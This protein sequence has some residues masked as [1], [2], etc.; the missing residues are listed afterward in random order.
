M[1]KILKTKKLLPLLLSGILFLVGCGKT[2]NEL[3]L[4]TA[5][6]QIEINVNEQDRL[7]KY[8]SPYTIC[9]K[10]SD[11]TYSM[12]IFESPIQFKCNNEYKI[13]NNTVIKSS[14]KEFA[15]ENKS[16]EIKT[17]FPKKL[18][19]TFRVQRGE[20]FLEFKLGW[21]IEGFSNADTILYKN[22]YGD[23]VSAIIY[24]RNDMHIIFYPTKAGIKT[25]IVLNKAP[26]NTTFSFYIKSHA[27]SYE[28]NQNGYVR[29]L[30]NATG[31]ENEIN[32]GIIYK[33]LVQY[34]VNGEKKIDLESRLDFFPT[35]D[36]YILNID[37][38]YSIL[39]DKDIEYPIKFDP[40]FELH[41]E[42]TPDSAVYSN[43]NINNFLANY[44]VVGE[45]P[46][47]GMGWLYSRM[48]LNRY[49]FIKSQEVI[50]AEFHIKTLY[51]NSSYSP[52]LQ[53]TSV[54]TFWSSGQMI[55]DKRVLPLKRIISPV[56]NNEYVFDVTGFVK[57]VVTDE[58]GNTEIYG[59]LIQGT[60]DSQGYSILATSDN[61]LYTPYIHLKFKKE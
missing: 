2:D 57:E 40:S 22:M 43:F 32:A 7:S 44:A 31:E 13:I 26:E 5:I 38:N 11:N 10:N 15:Y 33:P 56:K 34:I 50:S 25:E 4:S 55:W 8:D 12:Y 1:R 19:E 21:N 30:K 23:Q 52:D 35:S 59:N 18:S 54:D 58:T 27:F 29:L 28:N 47:L 45:H 9:Y 36:E 48:Y 61:S 20:D 37:L 49:L 46:S 17:Y 51:S 39:K 14:N 42:K 6:S 24:K 3:V 41:Q 53:M 16:N 60:E